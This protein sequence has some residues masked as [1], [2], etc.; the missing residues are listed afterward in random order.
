MII[1]VAKVRRAQVGPVGPE[2]RQS[3][4]LTVEVEEVNGQTGLVRDQLHTFYTG[5]DDPGLKGL[6]AGDTVEME[7]RPWASGKVVHYEFVRFLGKSG[8]P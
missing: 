2:R 6:E 1:M 3:G 5:P 4:V 7:V 8:K